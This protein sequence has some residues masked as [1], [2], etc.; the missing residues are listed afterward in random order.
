M[1][2]AQTHAPFSKQNTYNSLWYLKAYSIA[3][4][5]LLQ[6]QHCK[7]MC[8]W[9]KWGWIRHNDFRDVTWCPGLAKQFSCEALWRHTRYK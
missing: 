4:T 8:A 2:Q 9:I 5:T 7:S 3:I 1:A 6:L